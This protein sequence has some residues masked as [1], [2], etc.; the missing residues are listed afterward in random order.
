M[1]AILVPP[2]G[3]THPEP[4]CIL[5]ELLFIV[6]DFQ[7]VSI[8]LLH[9]KQSRINSK[10]VSLKTCL[11]SITTAKKLALNVE[12]AQRLEKRSGNP[13]VQFLMKGCVFLILEQEVKVGIE[14]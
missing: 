3:K 4:P 11:D 13:R 9:N 2:R 5:S 8:I 12:F 6:C 14:K 10:P 1:G 7:Q